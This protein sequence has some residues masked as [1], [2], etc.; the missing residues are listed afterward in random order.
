MPSGN[1]S[2]SHRIRT[3]VV[4]GTLITE[5]GEFEADVAIGDDGTILGVVAAGEGAS[6]ENV[7]D[8][9][10]LLV[11]AGG[12]DTHSHLN[13]PGLTASED[14]QTGTSGAAGGGY[15]TVLEMP[16]TQ[17][18]VDSVETFED[19]R[20][21]VSPK[22]VVDFG[23]YCALVPNN[24]TD[25]DTLRNIARAGA[26]AFKGFTCDTP[27]MPPLSL[28]QLAQGMRNAAQ[29]GLVVAVHCESQ[30]VIDL[31]TDRVMHEGGRDVSAVAA[32]HPLEAEEESVRWALSVTAMTGGCLHLVHMSDPATVELATIAKLAG[33]DVSVETC[34]HYLALTEE[35]L[36]RTNGWALCFPPLRTAEAVDG[37]WSAVKRGFIDAIGS[38]HCAYTLDQKVTN[39]PWK[40]LPG[41]NGMQLSLPV[42][43]HN[44]LERGVPLSQIAR[45]FS[46]NPARRFSLYPRKGDIRP[47]A[48]ADLV[49]VDPQAS[50]T[51]RADEL[52]TRCPG[53]VYEGMTFRGR[54]RRTMVRG[55]TVYLD[56]DE[57]EIT[58]DPGFGQFL[59]GEDARGGWR[60][61][62]S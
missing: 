50:I 15:T 59:H 24:A 32:T 22:A 52:F 40:I 38:D 17:P 39:D 58:V 14:F 18:L 6:A 12:V 5:S 46:G 27:E 44:A 16:Q 45:A 13:D 1:G 36:V 25:V 26:I 11:F 19:K 60:D 31:E 54:V 37:L 42:L 49:L 48:D 61:R 33:T 9:S 3:A 8:A 21:T 55:V 2:S 43:V 7:I 62:S 56:D 47:G 29:V 34:P 20:A 4:G 28:S 53:T 35:E 23:L 10:G 41:I 30:A 51:A 57:P